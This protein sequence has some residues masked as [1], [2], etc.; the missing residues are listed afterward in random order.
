MI[1][2]QDLARLTGTSVEQAEARTTRSRRHYEMMRPW[3]PERCDAFLDIGCGLGGIAAWVAHHYP[4]AMAHLLDGAAP[5][6]KWGGYRD[7]GQPWAD[8]HFAG[9]LFARHCPGRV[10]VAWTPESVAREGFREQRF[11]LVYSNCSWGHHYS[12]D[13]YIAPVAR[14]MANGATLI[15]DLRVGDIGERGALL[16]RRH[17]AP[18]NEEVYV[19]K[20]YRRSVWRRAS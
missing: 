11:E 20:K 13:T 16:L 4:L 7:D 3:L 17:F 10:A 8:V 1:S 2:P 12:I 9:Q 18:V 14:S 19:G 5:A 15:V 6:E